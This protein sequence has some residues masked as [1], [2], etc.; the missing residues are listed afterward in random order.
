MATQSWLSDWPLNIDQPAA[1]ALLLLAVVAIAF[2][3]FLLWR[4]KRRPAFDSSISRNANDER[5]LDAL[6]PWPD[7]QASPPRFADDPVR[8]RDAT[9]QVGEAAVNDRAIGWRPLYPYIKHR[10]FTK[11]KHDEVSTFVYEDSCPLAIRLFLSHRWKTPDDPDPDS[12]SL[13]TIVEYLSR[14][15]MVAN[16]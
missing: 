11:W 14:V 6:F 1:W 4:R 15:Y 8:S 2:V 9:P 5:D 12:Q 7:E 13:P 3:I 10:R 16:E